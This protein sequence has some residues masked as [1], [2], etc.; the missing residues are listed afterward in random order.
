V[1]DVFLPSPHYLHR[2]LDLLGDAHGQ[3][4]DVDLETASE[5]AAQEVVVHHH[6]IQREPGDLSRRRLHAAQHL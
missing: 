3:G 5:R 1:L 4:L 2:P 6:L